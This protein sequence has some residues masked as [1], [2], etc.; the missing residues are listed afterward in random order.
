MAR[1]IE[2]YVPA[3][4]RPARV[5]R[6]SQTGEGTVIRFAPRPLDRYIWLPNG[7]LWPVKKTCPRPYLPQSRL[8]WKP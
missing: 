3:N 1:L 6:T 7:A 2:F 8:A 4:F 5:Q